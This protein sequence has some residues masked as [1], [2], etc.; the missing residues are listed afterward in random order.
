MRG[1][2]PGLAADD[3][4][5][6][7]AGARRVDQGRTRDPHLHRLLA[8][9]P[10]GAAARSAS[11]ARARGERPAGPPSTDGRPSCGASAGAGAQ[12][13]HGSAAGR[14]PCSRMSGHLEGELMTTGTSVLP[15]LRIAVANFRPG[16]D[17]GSTGAGTRW[18]AGTKQSARCGRGSRTLCCARRSPPPR[19]AACALACG[20]TANT[21][22]MFPAARPARSR[23]GHWPLPRHLDLAASAGLVIL[24][25]PQASRPP[26]AG[27]QPA[28][29]EALVQV[30][31]WAHPLRAYSVDLPARSSTEQRAQADSP[32]Q[33]YR[34]PG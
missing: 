34:R 4:R 27:P 28:W 12:G 30:P 7:Q 32:G 2:G 17:A 26:G 11:P 10:P 23:P 3:L 1:P 16:V 31:G 8:R 6:R 18:C 19:R 15:E 25:A 29:C 33:P 13:R 22:G 14:F 5:S 21:L 9:L 20:T 24:D